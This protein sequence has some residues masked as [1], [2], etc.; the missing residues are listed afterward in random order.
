M[1]CPSIYVTASHGGGRDYVQCDKPAGHKKNKEHVFAYSG[2]RKG[3][4]ERWS[5]AEEDK[6]LTPKP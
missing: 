5:T 4:F 2:S 6:Q 3:E 1:R